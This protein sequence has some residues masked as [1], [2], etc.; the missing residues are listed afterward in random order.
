MLDHLHA[1]RAR[2][3]RL[4]AQ[5]EDP[6][7]ISSP[8]YQAGLADHARLARL[9]DPFEDYLRAEHDRQQ[10]EALLADPD[11][12]GEAEAEIAATRARAEDGLALIRSRLVAGSA[13]NARNAILEI[14][15]GTGGDEACLFAGDLVRM[16]TAWATV[17]GLKLSPLSVSE[18]ERGGYKDVS[19]HVTGRDRVTD[20]GAFGVLRFESGGHRVQRVPATE[21]S[22]RIHTSAATVAVL[23]E[24]E[25]ADIRIAPDDLEITT[26]K[27]G[28]AGGQHVNKTESAIRILHKPSGIA[29]HCQEERSQLANRQKAMTYLRARL[30]DAERERL[31]RERAAERKAQVGSGDRSDRIRTYNVPQN[32]MT[33]HRIDFTSYSLDRFMA[34]DCDALW[35]SLVT[36][37]AARFLTAWD[38]SF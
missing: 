1:L 15:A 2:W 34:G 3:R 20:G 19:F 12:R 17:R 16:Y 26:Q 33:D 11:L 24:V 9:M 30:Y 32:R 21:A 35:H 6:A 8:A 10:A 18:G 38:G 27:A 4:S 36:D 28:G 5:L 37:E 23:G 29:V 31:E 25:E 22:G 13:A 14:R 7:F